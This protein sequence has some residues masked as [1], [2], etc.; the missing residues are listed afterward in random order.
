MARNNVL[1]TSEQNG[2][3][4]SSTRTGPTYT[5]P[6]TGQLQLLFLPVL[7]PLLL[8]LLLLATHPLVFFFQ[9]SL[10]PIQINRNL[11]QARAARRQKRCHNTHLRPQTH[12]H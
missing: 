10:H 7:L 12:R 2:N 11:A 5:P 8:S 3:T 4:I 9:D 1:Y 6:T